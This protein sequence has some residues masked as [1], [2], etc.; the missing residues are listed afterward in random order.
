V[1]DASNGGADPEESAAVAKN[2]RV[3][4]LRSAGAATQPYLVKIGRKRGDPL[5]GKANGVT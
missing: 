3:G 1:I 2:K 4:A 5:R